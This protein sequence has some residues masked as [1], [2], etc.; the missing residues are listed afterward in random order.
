MGEIT[1]AYLI[2][3]S[4]SQLSFHPKL[5]IFRACNLLN[6]VPSIPT[7]GKDSS[8]A[9]ERRKKHYLKC[10]QVILKKFNLNI[11]FMPRLRGE[12]GNDP[13]KDPLS[14][15]LSAK[16]IGCFLSHYFLWKKIS[17]KKDGVYLI[18]ED[19]AYKEDISSVLDTYTAPQEDF[20]VVNINTRGGNGTEAYL[21]T[22]AAALTLSKHLSNEWIWY[23]EVDCFI[24][25]DGYLDFED[26]K[27]LKI[28]DDLGWV[29]YV[30]K[31][32]NKVVNFLS[33]HDQSVSRS[34]RTL[35]TFDVTPD[36]AKTHWV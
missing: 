10:S 28:I 18:C 22:P 4:G 33:K 14:F 35:N 27:S 16:G 32:T 21:I 2:T 20:S 1:K 17:E 15:Y 5:D 6:D 7:G 36:I 13:N 26:L 23:E 11:D 25:R 9:L 29:R 34:P 3:T 30:H 19:K 31:Q 24:F 8:E 12:A